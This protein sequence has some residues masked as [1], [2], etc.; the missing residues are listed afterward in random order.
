MLSRKKKSDKKELT[1]LEKMIDDAERAKNNKENLTLLERGLQEGN[2]F[3][4]ISRRK[5]AV[6]AK[7]DTEHKTDTE[8]TSP[9]DDKYEKYL[10]YAQKYNI[11]FSKSGNKKSYKDLAEDIHK[12][13][14][15]NLKKILKSGMDKK[16][17][18]YGHY[19]SV[20]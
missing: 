15:K 8:Y 9:Y 6:P 4:K 16:Y 10:H 2:E 13:E 17:K 18:E 20:V 14:M 19:I 12:Y 1:L 5:K 11:P 7:V 3:K